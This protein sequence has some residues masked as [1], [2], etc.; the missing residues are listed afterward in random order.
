MTNKNTSTN[1][2]YNHVLLGNKNT[3]K[4]PNYNCAGLAN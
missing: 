4:N 1:L 2:R 3:C